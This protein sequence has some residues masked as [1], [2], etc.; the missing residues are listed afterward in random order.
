VSN[1]AVSRLAASPADADKQALISVIMA[2]NQLLLDT[3][4]QAPTDA[5]PAAPPQAPSPAPAAPEPPARRATPSSTSGVQPAP[6]KAPAS[7]P[8]ATATPAASAGPAAPPAA[9]PAATL[10]V[11]AP[12]PSSGS[13]AQAVQAITIN[14]SP[15][16]TSSTASSTAPAAAAPATRRDA[17]AADLSPST[18]SPRTKPPSPRGS[19]SSGSSSS[20]SKT[21]VEEQRSRSSQVSPT[22]GSSADAALTQ[23]SRQQQRQQP[24][25]ADA[26]AG[27]SDAPDPAKQSAT[28]APGP[29]Q[30]K[31]T[32]MLATER[33]APASN[34]SDNFSTAAAAAKAEIPKPRAVAAAAP[35]A[36]AAPAA[37]AAPKQAY[38]KW[39]SPLPADDRTIAAA[40]SA[41]TQAVAEVEVQAQPSASEKVAPPGTSANTPAAATGGSGAAA[42]ALSAATQMLMAAVAVTDKVQAQE[43]VTPEVVTEDPA[44]TAAAADFDAALAGAV[45]STTDQ[46]PALVAAQGHMQPQQQAPAPSV[47]QAAAATA[48]HWVAAE[49]AE[50]AE[51][52]G[53]PPSSPPPPPPAAGAPP[54]MTPAD[55][56]DIL[57]LAHGGGAS[58]G[59]DAGSLKLAADCLL[60]ALSRQRQSPESK[61]PVRVVGAPSALSPCE[62][63]DAVQLSWPLLPAE[64]QVQLAVGA[65][66][67][68]YQQ[69]RDVPV[70]VPLQQV[71]ALA[72]SHISAMP[73]GGRDPL[74]KSLEPLLAWLC[75]QLA[76]EASNAAAT[77]AAAAKSAAANDKQRRGG[78][79]KASSSRS[80]VPAADSVAATAALGC[81]LHVIDMGMEPTA[82]DTRQLLASLVA[83][84]ADMPGG[85]GGRGPAVL[86]DKVALSRALCWW[87]E[88]A[89]PKELREQALQQAWQLVQA[90]FA[91]HAWQALAPDLQVNV[92]AAVAKLGAATEGAAPRG[93]GV[94]NAREGQQ[95][96]ARL[97][98]R[99]LPEADQQVMLEA[100][101]TALTQLDVHTIAKLAGALSTPGFCSWVPSRAWQGVFSMAV[102]PHVGELRP[103]QLV[104]V[105]SLAAA[106]RAAAGNVGQAEQALAVACAQ[107]VVQHI[108]AARPQSAAAAVP[109]SSTARQAAATQVDEA[110]QLLELM[111]WGLEA[112]PTAACMQ[113][114]TEGLLPALLAFTPSARTC[115]RALRLLPV[116]RC[117]PTP[118][119]L[120]KLAQGL[121]GQC[122][123]LTFAEL[124]GLMW[125]FS[126][127]RAF[128]PHELLMEVMDVAASRM[129]QA[130]QVA[131][132]K[133]DQ[134]VALWTDPMLPGPETLIMLVRGMSQLGVTPDEDWEEVYHG[135][136][137]AL[138]PAAD[139]EQLSLLAQVT[140]HLGLCPPEEWVLALQQESHFKMG[141]ADAASLCRLAHFMS[142][143]YE[144]K[145]DELPPPAKEWMQSLLDR[146]LQVVDSYDPPDMLALQ[147]HALACLRWLPPTTWL[148]EWLAAVV[149]ALPELSPACHVVVLTSLSDLG[150]CTE[151]GVLERGVLHRFVDSVLKSVGERLEGFSEFELTWLLECLTPYEVTGYQVRA[152]VRLCLQKELAAKAAQGA[153]GQDPAAGQV[154]IAAVM[155]DFVSPALLGRALRPVSGLHK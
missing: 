2:V 1:E 131:G 36:P 143:A 65:S 26:P 13:A 153:A 147:L 61:P 24:R 140:L 125:A 7:A 33:T 132:R 91:N 11:P 126:E 59:S 124:A 77:A 8:G 22:S 93:K 76:S 98:S 123:S 19:S 106:A 71:L 49:A 96:P 135:L 68:L 23:A 148:Q 115:A 31:P 80:R 127:L 155:M 9:G 139:V 107:A 114:V 4:Q 18:A 108:Q 25:G 5:A 128:P 121:P 46:A 42:A 41:P 119:A 85:E 149:V 152:E 90:M 48:P 103:A 44:L 86:Q 99:A 64:S 151:G 12:K 17:M 144:V 70:V 79:P 47:E 109:G 67:Q 104:D 63:A 130:L 89:G 40:S 55:A 83:L 35:A 141:E 134:D 28:L 37:A 97:L 14:P 72:A 52:A 129:E 69:R 27:S 58:A 66:Q 60:A 133:Q 120:A 102:A 154:S 95:A 94:S 82:K 29:A 92:L 21:L 116:L 30:P 117:R 53:P 3:A 10:T 20:S 39:L 78:G 142:S 88:Q 16:T 113:A 138:M 150:C 43:P 145:N 32:A 87:V 111:L 75:A 62:V 84:A 101:G 137:R 112:P 34:S 122:A 15:S 45:G 146:S 100:L 6:S 105:M 81:I 50:A 136:A 54:A 110:L 118:Q 56:L 57:R 38:G 73:H 74:L 51:A